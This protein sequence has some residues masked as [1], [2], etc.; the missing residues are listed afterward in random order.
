VNGPGCKF[1]AG[2]AFPFDADGGIACRRRFDGGKDLA[3]RP[4]ATDD[5]FQAMHLPQPQRSLFR[6]P[7]GLV[8]FG[9]IG[10]SL[11]HPEDL[12]LFVADNAGILDNRHI[13]AI[14]MPYQTLFRLGLL[15]FQDPTGAHIRRTFGTKTAAALEDITALAQG[16]GGAVAAHPL[17]RAVP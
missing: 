2:A 10:K 16:L 1:L 6:L 5:I 7:S 4:T 12:A 15:L 14:L 11:H 8:E 3:H 13:V 17:H 9:E